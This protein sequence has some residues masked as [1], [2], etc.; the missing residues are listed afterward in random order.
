VQ[1]RVTEGADLD[2]DPLPLTKIGHDWT[3]VITQDCDLEQDARARNGKASQ[4]KLLR[5]VLLCV[6]QEASTLEAGGKDIWKR[7]QQNK[8]ERYQFLERVPPEL[9]ALEQGVPELVIDFKQY[10]TLPT[11]EL[12]ERVKSQAKRRCRLVNEYLAH[13]AS[14]FS[15]FQSRVALPEEHASE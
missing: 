13:L 2:A 3:V 9:D 14:R 12:Y 8:D 15:Y 7:I 10:F 11:D 5:D 1:V 6:A 4:D